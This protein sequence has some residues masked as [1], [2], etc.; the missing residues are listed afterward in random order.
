MMGAWGAATGKGEE[1][2]GGR[3]GKREKG[4]EGEGEREEVY[5]VVCVLCV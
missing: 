4:R 1:E 3:K 5:P 2:K